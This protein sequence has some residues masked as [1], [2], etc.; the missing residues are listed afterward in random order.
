MLSATF[1]LAVSGCL[2]L[3]AAS[4]FPPTAVLVLCILAG[5]GTLLLLPGNRE[6]SVRRIGGVVL[7]A[8]LMVFVALMVRQAA[9]YTSGDVYFW[10]FSAIAVI[11][12]V[13]VITQD[14][15]VY[16]ALYFV[17]T[18]LASAGL[19]VLLWAEFMAAALILI[20][21]GAILITYV[22][23]I[24]LASQAQTGTTGNRA[25]GA[26]YD[27]V[28]REPL[29]AT[30]AGFGL[31]GVLLFVIFDKG[32]QVQRRTIAPAAAAIPSTPT[33]QLPAPPAAQQEPSAISALG[34]YLFSEQVVT[35]E[36]AGVIL[37]ISMVGAVVIARRQ[38][39]SDLIPVDA[40]FEMVSAGIVPVEDNPHAIPV[41]GTDSHQAKAYPEK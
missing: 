20:Y 13:R 27:R 36:I 23:V 30:A 2:P 7:L 31:M 15:P 5:V 18:V 41:T 14:R 6:P 16:S 11:S 33:V 10:L 24:M 26:E 19:F 39:G 21:A 4:L 35:L 28:S 12:A 40:D 8:A 29:L 17:L 25:Q 9:S 1:T 3:L 37:T 22:F 38:T 32:T 34:R